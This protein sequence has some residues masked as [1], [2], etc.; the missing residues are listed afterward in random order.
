MGYIVAIQRIYSLCLPPIILPCH[1]QTDA[2]RRRLSI[3]PSPTAGRRSAGGWTRC[4]R[5]PWRRKSGSVLLPV[6]EAIG[7]LRSEGLIVHKPHQGAFAKVMSR[8]EL[9]D[10][11]EFR[12]VLRGH[13]VAQA[14]RR[15]SPAQLRELWRA[16]ERS[17]PCGRVASRAAGDRSSRLASGLAVGRPGASWCCCG[18]QA[19]VM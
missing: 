17:L 10:L 4:R 14:A 16:V 8:V 1:G 7:Q 15:I 6:R 5:L 12:A 13:A 11:I 9:A 2:P 18:Q 19:T 3:Y